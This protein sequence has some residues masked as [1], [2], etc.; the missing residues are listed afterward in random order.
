MLLN[1]ARRFFV[2]LRDTEIFKKR[3]GLTVDAKQCPLHC[4]YLCCAVAVEVLVESEHVMVIQVQSAKPITEVPL[5][6]IAM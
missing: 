6:F 3:V 2:T 4:V 5:V 1:F